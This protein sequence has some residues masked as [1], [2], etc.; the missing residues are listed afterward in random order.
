MALNI[1]RKIHVVA[2][3]RKMLSRSDCLHTRQRFA[4]FYHCWKKVDLC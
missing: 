1:D 3:Q 4:S 2:T